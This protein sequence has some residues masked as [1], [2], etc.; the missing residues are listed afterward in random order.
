VDPESLENGVG[1]LKSLGFDVCLSPGVLE[2]EGFVAGSPE[3]RLRE[4]HDLLASE[5][6]KGIVCARGGSGAA[7]LLKRLDPSLFEAH[8]KVFVGYSDITWL[9][10]FANRLGLVTFYGPMTARGIGLGSYDRESLLGTLTGES[11]PAVHGGLET[12]RQ[13]NAEGRVLGGCLSLVSAAVGT[14][15]TLPAEPNTILF[16]EDVDEPPYRVE[17]MLFQLRESGCLANVSGIVFGEMPGCA[18]GPSAGYSLQEVILRALN[19]LD[20]P[21]ALGLPAGHTRSPGVTLPLGVSARLA[22]EDEAEL[23]LLEPAVE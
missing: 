22:C 16:L 14:P 18:P 8:H 2:R 6:V 19:G 1:E 13:G 12:L 3:T 17:R 15:W 5:A 11:P 23:R 21:V 7:H 4:L 9:H 20:I 10:L